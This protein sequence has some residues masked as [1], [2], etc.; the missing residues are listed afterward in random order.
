MR[1]K[2]ILIIAAIIVFSG[3]GVIK[4]NFSSKVPNLTNTKWTLYYKSSP[5]QERCYTIVFRK[6][7]HLKHEHPTDYSDKNERWKQIDNKVIISFNDSYAIYEGMLINYNL[8]IGEAKNKR[9]QKW[10]WKAKRGEKTLE[11]MLE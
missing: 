1:F 5:D 10:K 3:C 8:I 11:E 2:H 9:G 6:K 7:S 4:I